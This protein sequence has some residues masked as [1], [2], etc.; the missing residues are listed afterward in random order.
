MDLTHACLMCLSHTCMYNP[1]FSGYHS[2]HNT[3]DA[4]L[5]LIHD[6]RPTS[7]SF[8][9]PDSPSIKVLNNHTDLLRDIFTK[10]YSRKVAESFSKTAVLSRLQV[11]DW[12]QSESGARYEVNPILPLLHRLL[13]ISAFLMTPMS[14]NVEP[15]AVLSMNVASTNPGI[16]TLKQLLQSAPS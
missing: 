14:W 5:P 10:V 13:P 4:M 7:M 6:L 16:I 3:H 1:H 11:C 15:R 2:M 9:Y 8:I 12:S